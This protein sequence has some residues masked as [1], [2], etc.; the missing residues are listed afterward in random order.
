MGSLYYYVKKTFMFGEESFVNIVEP[1]VGGTATGFT[2]L[3]VS[4]E[5]ITL[6]INGDFCSEG[7]IEV[8]IPS[9]GLYHFEKMETKTEE[10]YGDEYER[11]TGKQLTVGYNIYSTYAEL[12]TLLMAGLD[13]ENSIRVCMTD[14]EG[15][16]KSRIAVYLLKKSD[17][18]VDKKINKFTKRNFLKKYRA[19]MENDDNALS[20]LDKWEA[21]GRGYEIDGK[22]DGY[23]L[24]RMMLTSMNEA[25]EEAYA[26][27]YDDELPEKIIN[28]SL[29]TLSFT[30]FSTGGYYRQFYDLNAT[31]TGN[32]A[33]YQFED[34]DAS[35][36]TDTP[37]V[38]S[39]GLYNIDLLY[40]SRYNMVISYIA[41]IT[42]RELFKI[43][44]E[45][46]RRIIDEEDV[47]EY[48]D[49]LGFPIVVYYKKGHYDM[50]RPTLKNGSGKT[51]Q[52]RIRYTEVGHNEDGEPRCVDE[53]VNVSLKEGYVSIRDSLNIG[54]YPRRNDYIKIEHI[55]NSYVDVRL[56]AF[57]DHFKI[58]AKN[59]EEN[60][61]HRIFIENSKD[62]EKKKTTTSHKYYWNNHLI[63][64]L[65][66]ILD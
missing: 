5:K 24:R 14:E 23:I 21:D 15:N 51:A 8:T 11:V 35:C 44:A 6:L 30:G 36:L 66:K 22:Y 28:E 56:P 37:P 60:A 52:L 58:A 48:L 46:V 4:E 45:I 3:D 26:E 29:N 20:F 38:E 9:D 19:W 59:Y 27:A 41:P 49:S 1:D 31:M 16:P 62:F 54:D 57:F 7:E 39:S 40:F 53:T 17:N 55:G 63:I 33:V 64:T 32:S 34:N 25:S 12:D 18:L 10:I 47:Q 61:A 2:V 65:D 50:L 43:H 42:Q 13:D